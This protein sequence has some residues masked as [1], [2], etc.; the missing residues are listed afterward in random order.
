MIYSKLFSCFS[1]EE[2]NN[3]GHTVPGSFAVLL[4][5]FFSPFL[6]LIEVKIIES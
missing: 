2:K 4:S 5:L 1:L 3:P 6:L